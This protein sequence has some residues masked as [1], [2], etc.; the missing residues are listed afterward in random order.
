M[1]KVHSA[2]KSIYLTT[3]GTIPK[4]QHG[5]IMVSVSSAKEISDFYDILISH[6]AI[7]E[8]FFYNMNED[9][10]FEWFKSKFKIVEAAGGLVKNPEGQYLFIFRNGKWDL[11]KGKI[12]KEES[13]EKAAVREVEEECGISQLTISKEIKPTYHTYHMNEKQVLKPTYWF[14]MDCSDISILVP[15]EEEGITEVRWISPKDF[16]IVKENTYESIKDVISEI[17]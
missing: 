14:K 2:D 16:E 5:R 17:N 6:N 8:I 3:T 7:K 4:L 10:L 9:L 11:P 1:I 15:Q 13:V 12:E